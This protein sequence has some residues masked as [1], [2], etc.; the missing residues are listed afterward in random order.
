VNY[1]TCSITANTAQRRRLNLERPQ[2]A[3]GA[4]DEIDDTGTQSYHALVLSVVRRATRDITAS[5]NYTWSH[6][7]SD[8]AD[9][10]GSSPTAASN[11]ALQDPDNRRLDRGN[12]EAD[13]R[14][15]FNLYGIAATPRFENRQL[16]MLMT[17]W[18]VSGIYRRSSG[19]YLSI[20]TG[21]DRALDGSAGQRAN[22][23][24]ENPFGDKSGRPQTQ[25]LNPAAFAIPAFGT[26]GTIGRANI[27]GPA[28]WQLDAGI[29]REFNVGETQR[30]EFRA[31][32]FNLTNSF[33]A[34]NPDTTLTSNVFG[35]IR[36]TFSARIMQF[37]LKY[38][39]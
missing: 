7:I 35:Q 39:F 15:L 6:C 24:Q 13:R 36:S 26:R 3:I 34:G 18:R 5:A 29:A 10:N 14:H 21:I 8:L 17:G 37:A 4:L 23:I 25:Y 32:A 27:E 38:V 11:V 33:R 16:R 19:S 1:A 28:T 2:E 22:W 30:V 9:P 31:E 20:F 12:C